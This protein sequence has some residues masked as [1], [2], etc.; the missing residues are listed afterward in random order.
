[1]QCYSPATGQ[2]LGLVNTVTPDG[3]D[4]VV[5]KATKAQQTWAKSSFAERRQVLKTL[6]KCVS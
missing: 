1:V 6:L 5:E 4:R 2:S 3:V